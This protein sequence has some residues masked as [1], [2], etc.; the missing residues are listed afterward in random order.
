MTLRAAGLWRIVLLE[1]KSQIHCVIC[2]F[3]NSRSDSSDCCLLL[4]WWAMEAVWP[5]MLCQ[6]TNLPADHWR[7]GNWSNRKAA[8]VGCQRGMR[9]H[10]AHVKERFAFPSL[11][12]VSTLLRLRLT[13]SYPTLKERIYSALALFFLPH[14]S[15]SPLFAVSSSP[16]FPLYLAVALSPARRH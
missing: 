15:P 2:H 7:G 1:C 9:M 6:S 4:W 8:P 3:E 10:A 16:P 11:C 12:S 5:N 14:R 13:S